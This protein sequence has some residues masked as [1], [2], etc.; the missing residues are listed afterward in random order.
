MLNETRGVP[1]SI[2]VSHLPFGPTV[3][4]NLSNVRMRHDVKDSGH[5]SEQYPHLIF[6]NLNSKTG[7]RVNKYY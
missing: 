7:L 4:F 3:F 6:H 2:I 5:M 1:D